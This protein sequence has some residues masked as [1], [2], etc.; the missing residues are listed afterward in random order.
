M[1]TARALEAPSSC[2]LNSSSLCL[3]I[4]SE[5]EREGE[6]R[7]GEERGGEGRRGREGEGEGEG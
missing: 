5:E 6:E 1:N 4:C 3:A 7:E 2:L